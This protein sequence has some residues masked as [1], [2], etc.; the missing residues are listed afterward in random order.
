[1]NE[2][3]YH[4]KRIKKIKKDTDLHRQSNVFKQ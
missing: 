3:V 1:M 4:I 2:F